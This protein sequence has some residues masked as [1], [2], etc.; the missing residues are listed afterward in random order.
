MNSAS[1][2]QGFPEHN[3]SLLEIELNYPFVSEELTK[4]NPLILTLVLPSTL[5]SLGSAFITYGS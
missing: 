1:L 4:P 2:M 3:N 5:I